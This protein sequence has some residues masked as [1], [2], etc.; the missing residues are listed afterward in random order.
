MVG[1]RKGKLRVLKT[2]KG[3]AASSLGPETPNISP[4]SK[5]PPPAFSNPSFSHSL[6]TALGARAT[7]TRT[8]TRPCP[9]QAHS[10]GRGWNPGSRGEAPDFQ[11]QDPAPNAAFA[12]RVG[13]DREVPAADLGIQR[14]RTSGE[15]L[16]GPTLALWPRRQLGGHHALARRA[17]QPPVWGPRAAATPNYTDGPT[18]APPPCFLESHASWKFTV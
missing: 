12:T 5:H 16:T 11:C 8:A 7:D 6:Y 10:I 14:R 15:S 2:D 1:V 4:G 17:L 3:A 18:D 13:A 9:G